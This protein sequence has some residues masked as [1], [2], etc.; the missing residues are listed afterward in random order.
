LVWPLFIVDGAGSKTKPYRM[1]NFSSPYRSGK[2]LADKI[3][4]T[5]TEPEIALTLWRVRAC[6][7][8]ELIKDERDTA[9]DLCNSSL[10]WESF[11]AIDLPSEEGTQ[12]SRYVPMGSHAFVV[13]VPRDSATSSQ[14]LRVE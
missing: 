6:L 11:A 12:R 9:C 7:A 10:D 2:H 8:T 4:I 1:Q 5:R 3:F 13:H 14:R